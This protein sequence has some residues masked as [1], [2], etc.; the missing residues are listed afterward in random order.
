MTIF[1]VIS[2]SNELPM[3]LGVGSGRSVLISS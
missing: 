3:T 1:E 2:L